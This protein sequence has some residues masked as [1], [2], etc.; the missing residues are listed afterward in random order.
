LTNIFLYG[1][2]VVA[3]CYFFDLGSY[4]VYVRGEPHDLN[5]FYIHDPGIWNGKDFLTKI[6]N[7]AN[8]LTA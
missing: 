5:K 1:R 7:N 4:D 8:A 6:N 2:L 3:D